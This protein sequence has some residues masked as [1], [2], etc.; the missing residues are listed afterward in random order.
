MTWCTLLHWWV[1]A[2]NECV[3]VFIFVFVFAEVS[4]SGRLHS[5]EQWLARWEGGAIR[6]WQAQFLSCVLC[7]VF[8]IFVIVAL[9]VFFACLWI[10]FACLWSWHNFSAPEK[11][12][13]WKDSFQYCNPS[14]TLTPSWGLRRKADSFPLTQVIQCHSLHKA[15]TVY[16][17]TK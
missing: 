14:L 2:C 1:M 11:V 16:T 4:I 17:Y 6:L 15:V 13:Y 9:K 7:F 5:G 10:C 12:L 8:G 3:F